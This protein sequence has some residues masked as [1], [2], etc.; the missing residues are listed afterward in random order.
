[1]LSVHIKAAID[2]PAEDV[3]ALTR[4]FN[5]LPGWVPGIVGSRIEGDGIGATRHLTIKRRGDQWAI[6]KLESFD[7][8]RFHMTYSIV[9][10]SLPVKTYLSS[11]RLLPAEDG[12]SCTLDW[13]AE[14][15]RSEER[16]VGKECRL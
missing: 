16:R 10:S 6:E 4:D 5:G 12:K 2:A 3:W 13:S 1:M 7:E 9:D 8:Q 14:F 15:E 11:F